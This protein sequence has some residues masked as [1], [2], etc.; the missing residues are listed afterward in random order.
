MRRRAGFTLVEMLVA[1]ALILFVLSILSAAFVAAMKSV[2]DFKAAGDLAEKERGAVST[3]RRDLS[4]DHFDGRRRWSQP[5][6]WNDGPPREGFFRLY[7]AAVPILDGFDVDGIPSFSST[8]AMLHY[9]VKLRGNERGDFFSAVVPT[10][11]NLPTPLTDP[12]SALSLTYPPERRYQDSGT[13]IPPIPPAAP[14]NYNWQ[15]AEVAVFLAPTG[16]TTDGGRPLFALYRRQMLAV[17]DNGLVVDAAGQHVPLTAATDAAGNNLFLEMSTRLALPDGAN[18]YFNS[19]KDLTMPVRRLGMNPGNLAG[20]FTPAYG[21][22]Y[23]TMAQENVNFV[24]ANGGPLDAN[25]QAADLLVTDVVSFD[26]RVLLYE[27][28]D[29]GNGTFIQGGIEFEDL[30][31]LTNPNSPTRPLDP[32]DTTGQT[33]VWFPVNN[34]N[35]APAPAGQPDNPRVLDTWSSATDAQFNYGDT[36]DP[37]NAGAYLPVWSTPGGDGSI[38]IWKDTMGNPIRVRA[39]QIVLRVWDFK[40]KKTRQVTMVQAM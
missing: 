5:D 32:R 27:P 37:K 18:L 17:P 6:F 15:W 19:P 23:P 12:A 36:P 39:I 14:T 40:T 25:Y 13:A 34:P 33:R 16:D 11:N 31:Q 26:V 21:G 10:P 7:Q 30:Y 3:L 35:F 38:P 9:A 22:R 1:M 28:I 29:Q 24:L 20:L 8:T 4:A 2:S